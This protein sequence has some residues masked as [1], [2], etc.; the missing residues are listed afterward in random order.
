MNNKYYDVIIIGTGIG[1]LTT[2]LS[3]NEKYS[4]GL[5]SK[6]TLSDGSTSLA[7]GGI[8]AVVDK[9]DTIVSHINDT[10]MAGSNYNN[11]D[12]VTFLSN[13]SAEAVKWLDSIGV[14]FD[15]TNGH[16]LTS[17]EAAHSH[18][19]IV[20]AT[21]FTGRYIQETLLKAVKKKKNIAIFENHFCV[22]LLFENK[23]CIGAQFLQNDHPIKVMSKNTVLATGGLGQLYQWTTNPI[24]ATGDGIAIASRGGVKI[25]DLE[26]IQFHPTALKIG[27]SPLFLLSETLR[28]EGAWIVNEAGERFLSK[29]LKLGE[30]GPRDEVSRAIFSEMKKGDIFLD[31]RHLNHTQTKKRFP[32][33]YQTLIKNYDLDITLDLIPITPA[34]H[35]SCGGIVTDLN[36]AT[37]LPGLYAVGE[38]AATG[39]HGANRLASNSLLEGVV[40]GRATGQLI[41]HS[42][43]S[44]TKPATTHHSD[45]LA[46]VIPDDRTE[47]ILN[48]IKSDLKK[49]MWEKV[50]IVRDKKTLMEAAVEIQEL[51]DLFLSECDYLASKESFEIQN[52]LSVSSLIITACLKRTK[53]LGAH[54]VV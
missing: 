29:H 9:T 53:S 21:D 46:P 48:D 8:A 5:Y 51:H 25:T 16:F 20:H 42:V 23:V 13:E 27:D 37:S 41:S 24:V 19:R 49:I 50:G 33:I 18:K 30:L 38:V 7:Q 36:G 14:P 28:G 2:A 10:L 47:T 26:F 4:V 54:Y 52:M 12:A 39:V 3:I 45:E 34:A 43:T 22:D 11:R 40:F 44:I 17:L 1:G 6:S 35:Y 31:M 15:K 32:N